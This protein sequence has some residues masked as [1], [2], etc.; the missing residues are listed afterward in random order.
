MQS[1]QSSVP[2]K[3]SLS[4][5]RPGAVI[6]FEVFPGNP[7]LGTV[8]QLR[9]A[10]AHN[11]LVVLS[12]V[13]EKDG[14]VKT[15]VNPVTGM[16]QVINLS[17]ATR[18]AT[19]G[20]GDLIWDTSDY[21]SETVQRELRQAHAD[22][23]IRRCGR[24][25]VVDG[26]RQYAP[27]L[28]RWL[29]HQHIRDNAAGLGVL[30]WDVLDLDR[31]YKRMEQEGIVR[32]SRSPMGSGSFSLPLAAEVDAARMKVFVRKNINRFKCKLTVQ[33]R[34]DERLD[35]EAYELEERDELM[36]AY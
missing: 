5:C 24:R 6:E 8:S 36:S 13:I 29:V 3:V 12:Q 9:M 34:E 23:T 16:P 33:A 30:P 14:T 18:V 35:A 10:G 17:H 7:V 19:H 22:G 2:F 31:L 11:Y 1:Q 28:V 15:G 21:V 26:H 27:N 4:V 20:Q 25:L 32:H